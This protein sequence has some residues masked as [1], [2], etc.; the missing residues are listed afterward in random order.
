MLGGMKV[1]SWFEQMEK[2]K[3]NYLVKTIVG[4]NVRCVNGMDGWTV[5]NE[6]NVCG[7]RKDDCA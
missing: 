6:R 5:L 3:E 4:Y 1:L 7:A 2:M